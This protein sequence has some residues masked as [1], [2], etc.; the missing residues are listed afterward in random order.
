[1]KLFRLILLF[2][3]CAVF[4]VLPSCVRASETNHEY[5]IV[6]STDASDTEVYAAQV[7]SHYLSALEGG[8]FPVISEDQSFDGYKFCIGATSVYDTSDITD[9][10]ADSYIIA[11]FRN[12]LA[13]YGSGSR[14]TI[15]GVYTFLEDFCG[16]KCYTAESGM[17]SVSGKMTLPKERI[18]YETF[19]E[20]RDTDWRSGLN[21]SYS[22]ANK[23][24]GDPHRQLMHEQGGT[25]AYLGGFC[26]TLSTV[27]CS[28]DKYF[29][30][31][32]DYFALHDGKRVP[33]QLCL[34]NDN[35]YEIVLEEVLS[36]LKNSHDP[37]ADFQII[38]LSQADNM[39]YC[40]CD[41]CKA[42]DS[43]NG[44][45]AGTMLTFVNRIA[46]AVKEEGYENVEFDTFAYTY[47]RKA[48]SAVV[49]EDNVIIRLCTFECCFSHPIDDPGCSENTELMRD[50][51]EWSEICNKMYIW[52][53][54]TNYACTLG[55]F[56]DFYVLQK[57]LQCFYEHGIR[58]V[59]EEGNYYI[60][61]CDTEFGD[62]RS[63]LISKLLE[64]PYCDYEA[65][66]LDFCIHYY[67]EGGEYIK[68]AID[69][70]IA[71]T[72][73]HVFI[74]SSMTESFSIDEKEA[75]KI[76]HLWSMAE[77]AA[78]KSDALVS[79]KRSKLSWRYLKAALGIREFGGTLEEN[80]NEREAL[81][82]DLVSHDVQMI[83][84]WTSIA[85]DF[86]EYEHIPVE[87]WEYATRLDYLQYNLNGGADGPPN[88]WC[89]IDE[90]W[91]PYTIPTRKG[92][93]FLGWALEKNAVTAEYPPG[94]FIYP[95]SDTTLYAVWEKAS[96]SE[97]SDLQQEITAPFSSYD[98]YIGGE[99]VD[100]QNVN[101]LQDLKSVVLRDGG[102]IRYDDSLRTLYLK[103]IDIIPSKDSENDGTAI[104]YISQDNIAL[105]IVVEG[106]CRLESRDCGRDSLMVVASWGSLHFNLQQDSVLEIEA[107]PC[108]DMY[109]NIGIYTYSG[110]TLTATGPGML[111][112]FGG[113]AQPD[114]GV[115]IAL[116]AQGEIIFEK[117]CSVSIISD[118]ASA[119]SIGC[120]LEDGDLTFKDGSQIQIKGGESGR[121]Y[122]IEVLKDRIYNIYAENWTGNM[123]VSGSSEAIHYERGM[124]ARI[125]KDPKIIHLTGYTDMG[126]QEMTLLNKRTYRYEALQK[127]TKLFFEGHKK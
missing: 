60:D 26:H 110:S 44:S 77:N 31:H 124:N 116:Y 85:Q 8:D 127:Y 113:D 67:G 20:F 16:Y 108:R 78:G 5:A 15:Y 63:Y 50:L 61:K 73:E 90:I 84:E 47:T 39:D 121:S 57:N 4:P 93:H 32:P 117:D 104:S 21:P 123:T 71:N 81:Y 1:M 111:R 122:G 74:Y 43:A 89:T 13:I 58:G 102:Y 59:Y 126:E 17:E 24:N 25:I 19:F 33:G 40:E 86:E 107:S 80:K 66:M 99:K 119:V 70:I 14:G 125:R 29:G 34:T 118:T 35:V 23:L 53:Y 109:T 36:L 98:L 55:I 76:D 105:T 48:P 12:G 87:E 97:D 28:S 115:S 88:Q 120:W 92:Y 46:R 2:M 79:I 38:S 11:P 6:I 62:L 41:T 96:E 75:E 72:Q 114:A 95:S 56:P 94:G 101:L 18:V 64:D 65:E 100:S 49:A 69:E 42:L 51:E 91:I 106:V 68:K 54:T 7:L 112:V 83:D 103:D 10:A 3:I 37:E 52:D 30:S 82:N 45:H 9:K 22:L 27:F